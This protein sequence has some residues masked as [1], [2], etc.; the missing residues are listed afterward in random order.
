MA[1]IVFT[2]RG[3]FHG[4]VT[5]AAP[6]PMASVEGDLGRSPALPRSGM[7]SGHL[8][9]ARPAAARRH[10][11]HR[12]E[13]FV[14][15]CTTLGMLVLVM[16][17]TGIAAMPAVDARAMIVL[18]GSMEPLVSAGDAAI[19]RD[20]PVEDLRVGN[21]ITYHGIGGSTGLTTHRI[22]DRVRLD[23]GLHFRTQGDA[24][25][26]PDPNLA[27]A[28]NV[29][30]RYD[31]RIPGGGRA[32][33]LLSRPEARI[34]LVALPAALMLA[35]ELRTLTAALRARS[36]ATP[37]QHARRRLALAGLAMLLA[38]TVGVTA[39]AATMAVLTDTAAVGDN[40]FSTSS[41]F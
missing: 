4:H 16:M 1:A 39:T 25:T 30:G 34:V 14:R 7:P 36:R 41:T 2:A 22:I 8:L 28:S 10:W 12:L 15:C 26:S 33:L 19:I 29:V 37:N 24:N 6:A 21:V 18:S 23:S 40:T 9:V 11:R 20:V 13:R 27:P 17:F 35:G 5:P 3:G 31:G 38:A 32:L